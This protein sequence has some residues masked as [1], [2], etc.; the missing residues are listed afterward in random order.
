MTGGFNVN[1]TDSTSNTGL[2]GYVK[3]MEFIKEQLNSIH[4][5]G[6]ADTTTEKSMK[7]LTIE[8]MG[9]EQKEVDK[10]EQK[11]AKSEAP[12]FEAE[13]A[14]TPVDKEQKEVEKTEQNSA[15]AEAPKF[16]ET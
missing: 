5:A 10:A 6:K 1:K 9:V 3:K 12:K 11:S 2:S 8:K 15:K 14:K 13:P 16:T 7:G 4:T